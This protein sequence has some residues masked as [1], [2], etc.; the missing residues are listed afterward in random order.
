LIDDAI[1]AS[2]DYLSGKAS[3]I[4]NQF[5]RI[6]SSPKLSRGF[7]D[8]EKA[9]MR[10]A[11]N[12]SIPQQTLNLLSGGIGQIATA[13]LGAAGGSMFGPTGG[14]LGAVGGLA[15]GGIGRKLAEALAHKEA[16]QVR[17]VV[18]SGGMQ[19]LPTADDDI[20]RLME[21]AMQRGTAAGLQQ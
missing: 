13:G 11:I 6:L 2:E 1:D 20:R 4:R 15:A 18:A 9:L 3:G 16:S 14:F 8:A 5:K 7:S 12:G 17:A 10:R 19:A 21:A